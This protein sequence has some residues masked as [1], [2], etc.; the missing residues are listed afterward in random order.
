MKTFTQI[1][2]VATGLAAL[3]QTVQATPITGS[4]ALSSSTMI[5]NSSSITTA[6]EVVNW[7][8]VSASGSLNGVTV[9][10]SASMASPWFFAG[11][12]ITALPYNNFWTVGGYSFQLQSFTEAVAG[13]FL[14]FTFD[15]LVTDNGLNTPTTFV[16]S[17]SLQ[18]PNAGHTDA[19]YIFSGSLSFNSP[20]SVPEGGSTA[21]LLG[22]ALT[23]LGLIRYRLA[24]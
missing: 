2:A 16:G 20:A 10:T 15:G 22:S 7:G 8:A 17:G 19:G 1:A 12:T 24:V 13:S 21:L 5:L 9:P 23:G 3:T 6:S 18:D 4:V 11:P 14:L